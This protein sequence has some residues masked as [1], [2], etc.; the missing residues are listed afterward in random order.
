MKLGG[1]IYYDRNNS[2]LASA[3][4]S[5][6]AQ[7]RFSV[8]LYP[9]L[10]ERGPHPLLAASRQ[11]DGAAALGK[12]L[13]RRPADAGIGPGDLEEAA[14]HVAPGHCCIAMASVSGS[15]AGRPCRPRSRFGSQAV[16]RPRAGR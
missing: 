15:T 3:S 12:R 6:A 1:G 13:G 9:G 5:T 8:N 4:F 7:D 2:L 14:L 10:I 16:N 11:Y